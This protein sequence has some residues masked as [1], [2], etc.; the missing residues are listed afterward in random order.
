MVPLSDTER[1][2][3]SDEEGSQ[4]RSLSG[5]IQDK[6]VERM[7]V[8]SFRSED[9]S[10]TVRVGEPHTIAHATQNSSA[11]RYLHDMSVRT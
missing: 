2:N 9:M 5:S 6:K 7:P 1:K 8:S 3:R 4:P 11:Q 10:M